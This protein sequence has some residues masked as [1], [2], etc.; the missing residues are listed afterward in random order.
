MGILVREGVVQV[1]SLCRRSGR[2]RSPSRANQSG[3]SYL[4]STRISNATLTVDYKSK[5]SAS[6]QRTIF[7]VAAYIEIRI[8]IV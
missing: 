3:D 8:E 2:S 1:G 5:F 6:I 7:K 4:I